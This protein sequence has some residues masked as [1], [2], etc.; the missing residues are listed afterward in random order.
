MKPDIVP[1]APSRRLER[2]QQP[3]SAPRRLGWLILSVTLSL[4]AGI[5]SSVFVLIVPGNWPVMR[6]WL[7]TDTTEIV[8]L[9]DTE[10]TA[11]AEVV[12][13]L[14]QRADTLLPLLKSDGT[15]A[16]H[17]LVVSNDG[18]MITLPEVVGDKVEFTVGRTLDEA[19]QTDR[20]VHDDFSGMS[21]VHVPQTDL[22]MVD[23]RTQPVQLGER[24]IIMNQAAGGNAFVSVAY[25]QSITQSAVDLRTTTAV[26]V[27]YQLDR[28]LTTMPV[29][30]P[31]FDYE[32]QL[33]GI[34]RAGDS[35]VPMRGVEERLTQLLEMDEFS[36]PPFEVTYTL[37]D[38]G[39][40][41]IS[42]SVAALQV[43]DVLIEVDGQV[44]DP[45]NDLAWL[46]ADVASAASLDGVVLRN[47]KRKTVH[48]D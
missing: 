6:E 10:V 38:S 13:L 36:P 12:R 23:F 30:S 46:M 43:D 48:I 19:A 21:F 1:T 44:V 17:A 15:L 32:G 5:V 29:G 20:I 34:Y 27:S 7:Q 37:D 2:A 31:V 16:G 42:S 24:V 40:K 35:V 22:S 18:W 28:T 33:V 11:T 26:N 8:I 47:G 3:A 39:A 25:L 14:E 45:T 4:A 41:I 9:P